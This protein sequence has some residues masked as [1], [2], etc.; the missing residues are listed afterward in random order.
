M[1]VHILGLTA[2]RNVLTK[3]LENMHRNIASSDRGEHPSVID[4]LCE[5]GED[6][7]VSDQTIVAN[8]RDVPFR[9]LKKRDV[10]FHHS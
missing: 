1:N 4:L 7:P 9:S 6:R 3:K 2:T 10:P 8:V 5:Q